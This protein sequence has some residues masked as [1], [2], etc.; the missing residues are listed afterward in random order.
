MCFTHIFIIRPRDKEKHTTVIS[1][2]MKPFS[3]N[4][5]EHQQHENK[6]GSFNWY[7]RLILTI[8]CKSMRDL[9]KPK[10]F[11]FISQKLDDLMEPYRPYGTFEAATL[12]FWCSWLSELFIENSFIQVCITILFSPLA[13]GIYQH[14]YT[15]RTVNFMK[16]RY[17][18]ILFRLSPVLKTILKCIFVLLFI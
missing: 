6:F 4:C 5:S 3:I 18:H 17:S 7:A 1:I 16:N 14:Y 15:I 9:T 12:L 11:T 13:F 2:R 8:A 10:V